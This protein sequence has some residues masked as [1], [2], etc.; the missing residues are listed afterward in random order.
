MEKKIIRTRFAPSP[1][2]ELHIG[3]ARTALF[4]YL[5]AKKNNGQFILR[6]E[7]TDFRRNQEVFINSLYQNLSWLGIKPDESIFQVG[8]YGSYRQTERLDIYR[9]YIDKLI[10]FEINL[11]VILNWFIVIWLVN[12]GNQN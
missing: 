8:E 4:S 1:T 5:L 9:K 12:S 2:G 3:G 11:K 7:D 10:Q 6:I